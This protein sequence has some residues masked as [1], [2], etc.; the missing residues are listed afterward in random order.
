MDTF[1][2]W[3]QQSNKWKP[4][5]DG[6]RIA[7][8]ESHVEHIQSDVTDV[9]TDMR[10]LSDIVS[11][12]KAQVEKRNGQIDV[13]FAKLNLS[14]VLDKVWWLLSMASMLA[15]MARGFKWI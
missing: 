10:K 3:P 7:R 2:P 9:K 5:Q 4:V 11:D 14:R 15:V 8:L 1:A 13:R 12:L 6:E